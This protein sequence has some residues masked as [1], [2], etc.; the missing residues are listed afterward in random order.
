MDM[1]QKR[2]IRQEKVKNE[3][4]E[5][6]SKSNIN[7]YPGHMAKTKKQ[8]IQDLKLIDIVIELLD[9]RIPISSQNPNI[10]EITKNKKKIIVLNKC[11][12]SDDKEN[13]RW[14][15][16]FKKKNIPAVL[17][18]SN[19]GRGI[20]E[21]IR[22]IEKIMQID[23]DAHAEKGRTGRRIRA[24]ILGIPNVGKSSFINRISKRTTAGVG[25]KPGVTK[26]KQWIRLSNNIELLDTPGVLW[27]KFESQEVALNLAFTG[28]IKD[29]IL[30]KVEVAYRL[31]KYLLENYE[32]NVIKRYK[33]E[34]E[35]LDEILSQDNEE[36]VNIYEVMCLIGK[37]R[38][39][40]VSG[41]NID[42]EKVS[43]IILDDFRTCKLGNITLE[44]V[45]K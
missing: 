41:G 12:L 40:I 32:D 18:D 24:M 43:N 31:L 42:D 16:Y 20:D 14:V 17:V 11:D 45:E 21:C 26:Q 23:L 9:A 15:E 5:E 27:P 36:N 4:K 33:I 2:K 35:Q 19:S 10:A 28:T 25:N 22:Q 29:D 37:K 13:K 38:G 39:C 7:W 6:N 30:P 8:I 3:D 44:K 34:K 1:Y